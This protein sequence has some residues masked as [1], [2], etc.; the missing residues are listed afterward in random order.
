MPKIYDKWQVEQQLDEGGQAHTFIVSDRETQGP[1]R[2]VLK[3]LK[4]LARL[5]RF[6]QELEA[7]LRIKH[8]NILQVIASNLDGPKPYIVSEYCAGGTLEKLCATQSPSV[9]EVFRIFAEIAEAV[10]AAHKANVIHRDIKPSNIFIRQPGDMPVL[11]DFGLCFLDDGDESE[12]ATQ[13]QEAVGARLFIAPESEDGML[14][15]VTA[16][17]DVYSLGKLLY[18]MLAGTVF[19]REKYRDGRWN[20]KGKVRHSFLDENPMMEHVTRLLDYMVVQDP[21]RRSDLNSIILSIH[22]IRSLIRR[23]INAV[24][25]NVTQHCTYCGWGIYGLVAQTPVQIRNFLGMEPPGNPDWRVFACN[26]C[27][28]VQL[29]RV[30]FAVDAIP[31]WWERETR[32]ES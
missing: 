30:D 31:T 1:E 15:K 23:E 11:G 7:A 25:K 20:L 6:R 4:N 3:R 24:G 16:K 28:H 18:W 32:S 8:R 21:E 14:E 26:Q 2:Y 22:R 13:T 19:S 12:R 27:G 5:T 10:E 17:V 9:D 29:F